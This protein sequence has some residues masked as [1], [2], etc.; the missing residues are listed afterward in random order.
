MREKIDKLDLPSFFTKIDHNIE[1]KR[2][3]YN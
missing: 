2:E 3:E 1:E